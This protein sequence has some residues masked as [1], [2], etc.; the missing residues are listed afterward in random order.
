[1]KLIALSILLFT[2]AFSNCEPIVY[3]EARG[4]KF[5][6]VGISDGDSI[7]V[8]D[9]NKKRE[10]VRLA[11]IDAPENGQAF[12]KASKQSLSQMIYKKHVQ[13][14]VKNRDRY[15]RMVGEVYIGELNA[16]VEQLRRGMA[17]HYRRHAG[18][19]S[20]ADRILYEEV[21]RSARKRKAGLWKD[22]DPTPP[23][24]YRKENP[25]NDR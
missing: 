23:W 14:I 16:N 24:D 12:G 6:V 11:T 22:K 25:R 10:R 7:V 2:F 17:W 8:V 9:E 15:G 20:R 21:E 3:D 4:E 5:L 1:M 13:V 18:E 19:Q